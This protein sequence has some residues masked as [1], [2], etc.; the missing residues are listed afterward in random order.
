MPTS[1]K[2]DARNT[3]LNGA[4]VLAEVRSIS[5]FAHAPQF[6]VFDDILIDSWILKGLNPEY[7]GLR[8]F[9]TQMLIRI[10]LLMDIV[11]QIA[12]RR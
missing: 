6:K 1:T 12:V 3:C 8:P 5:G 4:T 2:T 7:S 9:E 10:F 11:T